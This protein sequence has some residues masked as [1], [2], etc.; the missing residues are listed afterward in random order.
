MWKLGD[1]GTGEEGHQAFAFPNTFPV[2]CEPHP[3]PLK[4]MLPPRSLYQPHVAAEP[5]GSTR[6]TMIRDWPCSNSPG[7]VSPFHATE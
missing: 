7:S 3:P 1:H 4:G 5:K 6:R 2:P